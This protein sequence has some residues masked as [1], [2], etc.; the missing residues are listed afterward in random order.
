MNNP[1]SDFDHFNWLKQFTAASTRGEG[2]RELRAEIFH[3]TV[4]HVKNGGYS[5]NGHR[6]TIDSSKVAESTEF[7]DTP[8]KLAPIDT[9]CKTN[10]SVIAA[11]CLETA[12]VLLCAG[13]N[14]CVL[15]MAS[16]HNPG[17]GVFTG[18]GAQ[19]EN[20]FRRTNMCMSL[21]QY[22]DYAGQYGLRRSEKSYPLDRN[23]G[24]AYSAGI[25]A[26]R[27]SEA[28]GYC[29]LREPYTV[30]VV[31]V[32]AI[33]DPDKYLSGGEYRIDDSL[34]PPTK[35]KIRTILRIAGRHGHD[36]LVLGAFGCG[37]FHNPPGHMAELFREVFGEPE[38]NGRFRTIV[39]AI[40]NDHNSHREHNP[41]GNAL[42][43]AEVF[44]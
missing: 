13:L 6:V 25:M 43:F 32:A 33:K 8:F 28:N 2:F 44:G 24:G 42:P 15:N 7:F 16:R 11:D 39:F 4:Q 22:V 23:C 40:L 17:G 41:K 27:G 12:Q 26:F 29:L 36:S 30:S 31:S 18:A 3:D 21:F 37:A 34:V 35:E 1:V 19:E 5:V 38:F 9:L 14:P 10:F 20:L